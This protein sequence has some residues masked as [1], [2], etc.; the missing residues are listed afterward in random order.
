MPDKLPNKF[1]PWVVGDEFFNRT[2]EVKRRT[3]R[4]KTVVEEMANLDRLAEAAYARDLLPRIFLAIN[5]LAKAVC[6]PNSREDTA[7]YPCTKCRQRFADH[8]T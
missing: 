1:G 6:N 8:G 4:P 3:G 5:L 2:A 7:N